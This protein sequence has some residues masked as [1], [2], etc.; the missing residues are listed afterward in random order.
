MNW[1]SKYVSINQILAKVYRD[2]KVGDLINPADAIEWAGEAIELI[3]APFHFTEKVARLEISNHRSQL[4]CDLHYLVTAKGVS[5]DLSTDVCATDV[6]GYLPMRYSTDAYHYYCAGNQDNKYH[7][8]LTYKVNDDF[9]FT[10]FET[11]YVLMAYH[12]I[13]VDDDGYP[14]IPDDPKFKEAV[15][16]HIKWRIAFILA[17]SGKM[18]QWVYQKLE[19]DRDWYMA[20]AQTRA[21]TPSPDMA[22]AI[23]NNW[24]RLIPKINQHSDGFKSAGDQEARYTHNSINSTNYSKSSAKDSNDTFFNMVVNSNT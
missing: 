1:N 16:G 3:G 19:Q 14:L 13:P 6:K 24:L 10:S 4:P 12:G 18:P 17:G 9:I 15:A 2:L 23:K 8:S 11:G 7:A 20:A 5:C 22:E 21:N